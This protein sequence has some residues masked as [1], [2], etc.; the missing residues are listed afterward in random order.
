MRVGHEHPETALTAAAK[1]EPRS[2]TLRRAVFDTIAAAG[3][4]GATDDEIEQVLSRSHQSVSG[5]RN[6]LM[7]DGLIAD[8]GLRRPTRYANDAIAWVCAPEHQE[9]AVAAEPSLPGGLLVPEDDEDEDW[10]LDDQ[11]WADPEEPQASD[12]PQGHGTGPAPGRGKGWVVVSGEVRLLV[13]GDEFAP[14]VLT[15]IGGELTFLPGSGRA[16]LHKALSEPLGAASGLS[17]AVAGLHV[18]L[19]ALEGLRG[20][21]AVWTVEPGS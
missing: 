11:G 15:W 2:G 13:P 9:K 3:S 14:V 19:A 8:S 17:V 4:T 16:E 20:A 18:P 5:A 10:T 21:G 1:A 12:Q 7:R 6:T